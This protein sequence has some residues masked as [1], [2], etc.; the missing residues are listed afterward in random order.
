MPDMTTRCCAPAPAP[1]D[2]RRAIMF[3]ARFERYFAASTM[4]STLSSGIASL[5]STQARTGVLSGSTQSSQIEFISLK[6][7]I[8]DSQIVALRSLDLSL[9]DL[10]GQSQGAP[11]R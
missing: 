7:E 6:L 1:R 2:R 4:I 3:R 11:C 9:L 5:L 10:A 8:S